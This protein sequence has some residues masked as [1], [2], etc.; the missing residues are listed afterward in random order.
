MLDAIEMER[1][2]IPSANISTDA[3]VGSVREMCQVQGLPDYPVAVMR[4]P[5]SS[6]N[7]ETLRDR[8]N[9]IMPEILSGLL[10]G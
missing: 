3:F 5:L 4:H 9:G 7:A 1:L 10:P 6:L 2:G 8:I